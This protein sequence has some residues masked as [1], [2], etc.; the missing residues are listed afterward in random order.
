MKKIKNKFKKNQNGIVM[1]VALI[2]LA[3]LS[4]L[5]LYT[6]RSSIQGEQ[7]SKNLRS[8]EIATQSAEVALRYCED[9]VRTGQ[10]GMKS[11]IQQP[12]LSALGGALP[13][14]WKTR[15]NWLDTNIFVQLPKEML[16]SSGMRDVAVLPKCIVEQFSLPPAPGEDRQ[17]TA[18]MIPYLIT[19][20]G[21]SNDYELS[22]NRPISGGEVWL[23]TVLIP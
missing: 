9:R 11:K 21:Y 10:S 17:A 15:A 5:G 7:I 14:M 20:V 4:L 13:D 8:N 3:I 18:I 23:Q 22:N 16:V 12:S 6:M 1:A 2:F 19:A